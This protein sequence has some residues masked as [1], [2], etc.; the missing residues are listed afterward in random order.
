[1]SEAPFHAPNDVTE[2]IGLW[3]SISIFADEVEVAYGAAK[4]WRRRNSIPV[5]YRPFI[6]K[7]ALVRGFDIS[8]EQFVNV[9]VP[10]APD[11]PVPPSEGAA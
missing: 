2:L 3:P 6:Q 11:S 8:Y 10:K 1:M 5:E 4:Q 9:H 7:A